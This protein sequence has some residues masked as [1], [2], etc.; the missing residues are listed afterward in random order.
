VV[1]T[2]NY[3]IENHVPPVYTSPRIQIVHHKE[4]WPC[5]VRLCLMSKWMKTIHGKTQPNMPFVLRHTR[6]V[7]FEHMSPGGWVIGPSHL[8]PI[9][10]SVS[11]PRSHKG[12]YYATTIHSLQ[13]R[14]QWEVEHFLRFLTKV[15]LFV[16]IPIRPNIYSMRTASLIYHWRACRSLYQSHRGV[17]P[18]HPHCTPVLKQWGGG[19]WEH[20]LMESFF[21]SEANTSRG[22]QYTQ[23]LD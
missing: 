23:W 2:R 7:S 18:Y 21:V 11:G 1:I 10:A 14:G 5:W 4:Y 9:R 13:P 12:G 16:R 20:H 22:E 3:G 15:D 17:A 8:S 19:R 6:P